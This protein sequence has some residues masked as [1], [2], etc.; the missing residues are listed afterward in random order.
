MRTRVREN[1][2]IAAAMVCAIAAF[3]AAPAHAD[4]YALSKIV[5][6]GESEPISGG[7][8]DPNF[9]FVSLSHHVRIQDAVLA[10]RVRLSEGIA[11]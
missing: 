5:L 9:F 6:S 11:A 1:A 8:F 7:T 3:G 10:G 4:A 2:R